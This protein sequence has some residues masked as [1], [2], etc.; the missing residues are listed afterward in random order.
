MPRT[1]AIKIYRLFY[2]QIAVIVAARTKRCVDAMTINSA[3]SGS[4]DPPR[5]L[6]AI[7]K[8]AA[9]LAVI[10]ESK[11]F[12]LN[13]MD[14]K[15]AKS[16]DYLGFK[17]EGNPK[18]MIRAAGLTWKPGSAASTPLVS[19]AAATLECRLNRTIPLG[20]NDIVVGDVVATRTG[21]DFAEYWQ[22][23]SYKPLIYFGTVPGKKAGRYIPCG[24]GR[25]L[26]SKRRRT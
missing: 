3:I 15:F 6:C 13:W 2:P 7:K 11:G 26:A 21:R 8:G 25:G 5:V 16:V 14:T 18:D 4:S 12:S 1:N 17:Q 23:I 24:R 10:R 19:E 22:F 9:I 20:D